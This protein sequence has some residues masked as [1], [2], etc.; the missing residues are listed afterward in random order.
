M[1]GG[2]FEQKLQRPIARLAEPGEEGETSTPKLAVP[3]DLISLSPPRIVGVTRDS[4]HSDV[5]DPEAQVG[6]DVWIMEI[7]IY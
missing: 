2:V 3:A 5:Q 7:Q 1:P 4:V 6:L